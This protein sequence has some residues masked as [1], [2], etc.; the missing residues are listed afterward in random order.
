VVKSFKDDCEVIN[1]HSNRILYITYD[2]L[3]DPLGQSQVLAYVKIL[4]S[5]GYRFTIISFEKQHRNISAKEALREKLDRVGI[6]WYPLE[7]KTGGGFKVFLTHLVEGA[8]NTR[9]IC[10]LYSYDLIHLR[11]FVSAFI[12]KLSFI[13]KPYIYDFRSFTVYEWAEAGQINK[14]V[15]LFFKLIDSWALKGV[16]GLVTLEP[17]A[18]THVNYL[19]TIPK[20]PSEI[21]R[22]STDCKRYI[23]NTAKNISCY[24]RLVHLG[25]AMFPYQIDKVLDFVYKLSGGIPNISITFINDGQHD[26]IK[27]VVSESLIDQSLVTIESVNHQ[28]IPKKLSEFDAGL[29]FIEASQSRKVCSPTKLGEYLAAGLPILAGKG[30]DILHFIENQYDCVRTYDVHNLDTVREK[31]SI[32]EIKYFVKSK[33]ISDRCKY[34]AL[35][36][37]DIEVAVKRYNQLYNQC[38]N[39]VSNI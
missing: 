1:T 20:V 16:S 3:L 37:F 4:Q 31:K 33:D 6:K 15:F 28:D 5:K 23:S 38:I 21:I 10:K 35:K 24:Y 18:Q 12:Y 7:F 39:T 32:E 27:Q 36:H 30:I 17:G 34:V 26:K 2:G 11:G 22:T 13:T 29:V 14:V 19:Y 25:G 9:K 8:I